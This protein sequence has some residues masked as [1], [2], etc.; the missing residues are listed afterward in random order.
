MRRVPGSFGNRA[1]VEFELIDGPSTRLSGCDAVMVTPSWVAICSS[2]D[3]GRFDS[4]T[5]VL[6]T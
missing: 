3:S 4:I 2:S 5:T 1:V 6:A